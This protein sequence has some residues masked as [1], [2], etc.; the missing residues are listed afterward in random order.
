MQSHQLRNFSGDGEPTA[1]DWIER[2]QEIQSNRNWEDSRIYEDVAL[3]L[4]E[5]RLSV[6]LN[7]LKKTRNLQDLF[8]HIRKTYGYKNPFETYMEHKSAKI[9]QKPIENCTILNCR[10]IKGNC[11]LDAAAKSSRRSIRPYWSTALS[12]EAC[13]RSAYCKSLRDQKR[14]N[15]NHVQAHEHL[16]FEYE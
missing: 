6:V 5:P 1:D 16:N 3:V 15:D 4:F 11:R 13:M 12:I 14:A 2:V 9:K 10:F 8:K 7:S